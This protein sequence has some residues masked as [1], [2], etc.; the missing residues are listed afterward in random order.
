MIM[1]LK[2]LIWNILLFLFTSSYCL[3]IEQ[4]FATNLYQ[5]SDSLFKNH[6]PGCIVIYN[7]EDDD[8]FI[9]DSLRSEKRYCPASTYKIFN[10]LLAFESGV[11]QDST[12]T[13][14]WDS[15]MHSIK[16][17]NRTHSLNTAFKNSVVWYYQALAKKIGREFA[18]KYLD[19]CNYGNRTIGKDITRYWLDTSLQISAIE[20]IDFL[21]KLKNE[22]LPYSKQTIRNLKEIMLQDTSFGLLYY[23]TGLS[24]IQKVGWFVGWQVLYDKTYYFALNV[25]YEKLNSF[26]IEARKKFTLEILSKYHELK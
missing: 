7:E 11:A 24:I 12:F 3:A 6:Y 5:V 4:S 8:I 16:S 14:E 13:I 10:T 9:Y 21:K 2:R 25:S 23:K 17:W 20:Q 18:Q 15:T 1:S 19:S 22:E 26:F